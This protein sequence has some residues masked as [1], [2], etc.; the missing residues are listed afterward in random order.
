MFE[1]GSS[2]APEH[3]ADRNVPWA[4]VS[5]AKASLISASRF[6][7]IVLLGHKVISKQLVLILTA[8]SISYSD[9]AWTTPRDLLPKLL[10]VDGKEACNVC[11]NLILS[12]FFC[13]SKVRRQW[14]KNR[15]LC[16]LP[17]D[18][19]ISFQVSPKNPWSR[20]YFMQW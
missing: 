10:E 20:L 1:T 2:L 13:P 17:R 16:M 3:Y 9:R 18:N 14:D 4:A 15:K 7:V 11:T 12:Q 5:S 19:V 8:S 6:T